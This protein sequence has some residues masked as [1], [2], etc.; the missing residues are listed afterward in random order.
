MF[1]AEPI[2]LSPVLPKSYDLGTLNDFIFV[3]DKRIAEQQ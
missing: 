2:N 3:N 1:T